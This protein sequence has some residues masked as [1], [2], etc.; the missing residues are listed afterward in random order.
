MPIAISE[1]N[2][3]QPTAAGFKGPIASD[4][5][6]GTKKFCLP[7]SSY[8]E[9]FILKTISQQTRICYRKL[10]VMSQHNQATRRYF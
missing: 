3:M 2:K 4:G 10:F 5:F 7:P 1:T 8:P 6:C 9:L